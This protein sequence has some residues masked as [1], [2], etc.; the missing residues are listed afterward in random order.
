[1]KRNL[2]G[3]LIIGVWLSVTCA[4]AAPLY[5]FTLAQD[6]TAAS[7][8]EALAAATLQG[9]INRSSPELCLLSRTNARPQF[10]LDLLAKNNRWLHGR[11]QKPLRDLTALVKL[12]G[13]RLKG[14][15]IWDPAVPATIN[16][17]TTCAGVEDAVVLSPDL[18]DRY[19][20]EWKLAVL[21]DFRG[22]FTGQ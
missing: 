9:I 12:A 20:A 3:L 5:T 8:D 13:K 2:F 16:V 22:K 4:T 21:Q 15:V 1:M 19:V 11:K 14:A 17:A 18:A 10:W 7:Y 6:G